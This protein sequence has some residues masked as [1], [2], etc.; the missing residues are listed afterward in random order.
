MTDHQHLEETLPNAAPEMRLAERHAVILAGGEGSRLR[1]LTRF[2]EGDD[3]PK[4]FS[5][6]LNGRTLLD[7]TKART[8]LL[9]DPAN[10]HYSLTARHE[11]YFRPIL[12]GVAEGSLHIQPANKG[13]APALLFSLLR[14]AD[15]S[16]D[17]VVGFF[18]SDHYFSDD[19]RMMQHVDRAYRLVESGSAEVVLLGMEPLSAETS[20]GWIEPAES[21][22]GNVA[23]SVVRVERFWEKPDGAAAAML[24]SRGGLWNSFVF[25]GRL[26]TLIRQ[27]EVNLPDLYRTLSSLRGSGFGREAVNTIY[28]R[29][30]ESNYSSDVLENS[31][32]GLHVLRVSDVKWSDLGEPQRVLGTLG[33]LGIQTEVPAYAV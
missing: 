32:E 20:Y 1:S 9:I 30:K 29:V 26:S 6:I 12:E 19:R 11:E 10:T 24:M 13:T 7:V 4:Q 25:V 18:P 21:F 31:A 33:M 5:R 14:L 2:I 15:T 23:F 16:G 17:A 3:R 28:G 22:F 27:F 8:S